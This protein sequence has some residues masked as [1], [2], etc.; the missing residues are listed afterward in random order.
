MDLK[1]EMQFTDKSRGRVL[2]GELRIQ[3]DDILLP[4]GKT[5]MIVYLEVLFMFLYNHGFH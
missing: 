1:G 3:M 2:A 5:T 4:L